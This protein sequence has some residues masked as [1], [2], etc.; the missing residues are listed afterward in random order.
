MVVK[1]NVKKD[2]SDEETPETETGEA[3]EA[4][5][6]EKPTEAPESTGEKMDTDQK[7]NPLDVMLDHESE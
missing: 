7:T 3:T 2:E 4:A 5:Q 6:V 1:I